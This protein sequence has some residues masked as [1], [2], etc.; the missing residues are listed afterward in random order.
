MFGCLA[1]CRQGPWLA[2]PP[3]ARIRA[4][5]CRRPVAPIDRQIATVTWGKSTLCDFCCIGRKGSLPSTPVYWKA[6][7]TAIVNRRTIKGNNTGSQ[8]NA[9]NL[10]PTRV[11]AMLNPMV[12]DTGSGGTQGLMPAPPAG[13]AA[14]NKFQVGALSHLQADYGRYPE[15]RPSAMAQIRLSQ[16]I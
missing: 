6:C 9:A 12:G 13:S 11:T 4:G 1:Q 8:A 2:R 16:W 3:R 7:W 10:T 5:S 15:T 14:A